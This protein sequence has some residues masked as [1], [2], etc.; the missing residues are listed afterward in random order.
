MINGDEILH[1]IGTAIGG[2]LIGF[3]VGALI[4][5]AVK[6]SPKKWAVSGA[7]VGIVYCIFTAFTG[8]K[9]IYNLDN[10]TVAK[11]FYE[12]CIGESASGLSAS[13]KDKLCKCMRTQI[14]SNNSGAGDILVDVVKQGITSKL[15]VQAALESN[16]TWLKLLRQCVQV[17]GAG[18]GSQQNTSGSVTNSSCEII[19][20]R[21]LAAQ[22][23]S[24]PSGLII[25]AQQAGSAAV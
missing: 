20:P 25:Q 7:L 17:A 22:K 12:G 5:K 6:R 8:P 14:V 2:G 23:D 4:G 24:M 18:T 9:E 3:A 21:A 16:A 15:K 10:Q 13:Q 11:K 1:A 19:G